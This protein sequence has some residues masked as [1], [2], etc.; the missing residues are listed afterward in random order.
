A[1]GLRPEP[2]PVDDDGPLPDGLAAALAAGSRAFLTTLR[3]PNPTAAAAGRPRFLPPL[4]P[5][6]PPGAVAGPARL[7][8]LRRVLD[9][10]PE[11]VVVE[12]DHAGPVADAPGVTLAAGD[13]PAG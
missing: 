7:E 1:L 11:V 10:H 13:G 5:Q 2:V 9:A 8:E 4:R 6:N 12:D 3:A